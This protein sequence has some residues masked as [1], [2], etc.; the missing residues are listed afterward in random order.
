L[1]NPSLAHRCGGAPRDLYPKVVSSRCHAKNALHYQTMNP[2]PIFASVGFRCLAVE[3]RKSPE[4][5]RA[6]KMAEVSGHVPEVGRLPFRHD[7]W[8]TLWKMDQIWAELMQRRGKQRF[9]LFQG[10]RFAGL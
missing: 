1:S 10:V 9:A 7:L 2:H 8:K 3:N 5:T 4:Q 6:T